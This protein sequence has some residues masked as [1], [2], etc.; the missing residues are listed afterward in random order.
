MTPG[1]NEHLTIETTP[2]I[3]K[4]SEDNSETSA[5]DMINGHSKCSAAPLLVSLDLI[6]LLVQGM[7]EA[8]DTLQ[9]QEQLSRAKAAEASRVAPVGDLGLMERITKLRKFASSLDKEIAKLESMISLQDTRF[10][11]AS[12]SMAR[13]RQKNTSMMS[14]TEEVVEGDDNSLDDLF[15]E[16]D[17]AGFDEMMASMDHSASVNGLDGYMPGGLH[18]PTGHEVELFG[19]PVGSDNA[20]VDFNTQPPTNVGSLFG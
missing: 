10:E 7:L 16:V 13:W 18:P 12:E 3:Q 17:Q 19:H 8:I 9:E 2:T 1:S 20:V 4:P 15:G 5:I 11:M 6:V 14:P